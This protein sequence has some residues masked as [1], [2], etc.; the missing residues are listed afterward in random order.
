VILDPLR[1][2]LVAI[3][4]GLA[5]TFSRGIDY[6]SEKITIER[7]PD[8]VK[9]KSIFPNLSRNQATVRFAEVDLVVPI[10]VH[11]AEDA[12]GKVCLIVAVRLLPWE[13]VAQQVQ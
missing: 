9:L 6:L 13:P 10:G 1:G 3:G 4:W 11:R 2:L 8:E 12:R 7:F 5:E